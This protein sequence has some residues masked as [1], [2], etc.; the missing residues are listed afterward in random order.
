[1][2]EKVTAEEAVFAPSD[3]NP[4]VEKN[5]AEVAFAKNH[6]TGNRLIKK[7]TVV[8]KSIRTI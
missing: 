8:I 1:M 7:D 5:S 3:R 2:E 6:S 4:S